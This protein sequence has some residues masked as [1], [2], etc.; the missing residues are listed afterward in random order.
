MINQ[1]N[2]TLLDSAVRNIKSSAKDLDYHNNVYNPI[3]RKGDVVYCEFVGIGK[4]LNFGHFAIVWCAKADNENI[5]VIPLTSKLKDESIGEFNLGL[6]PGFYTKDSSG[7]SNRKSFIYLNKMM[8]VSR[9]RVSP[10]YE[11]DSSGK[12]IIINSKP[13][14]LS[15]DIHKIKRIEESM[16]MYYLDERNYLVDII[17][18]KIH[19]H[20]QLDLTSVSTNLLEC[21]YRLVESYSIYDISGDKILICHIDNKRYSI[22]FKLI[23]SIQ[24][25][26]HRNKKY[27]YLYNKIKWVNNVYSVRKEL[28]KAL[29]SLNIDKV[30]EA[31]QILTHF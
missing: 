22:R 12:I 2:L 3:Y 13:K 28:I 25:N 8:E 16:R 7:F 19:I 10:K 4:E 11:Q 20:Y 23:N 1:E 17:K 14:H 6:I 31:Q 18:N 30:S 5:T 21:G 27:K 29:F 26:N 24:I 15:I 9:K